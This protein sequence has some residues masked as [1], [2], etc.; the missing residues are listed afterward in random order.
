MKWQVLNFAAKF[1][2]LLTC[3]LKN[4]LLREFL[5]LVFLFN[6]MTDTYY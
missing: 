3:K 4:T 2:A 6:M 5:L 1:A